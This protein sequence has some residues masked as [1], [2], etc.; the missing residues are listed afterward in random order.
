MNAM[1]SFRDSGRIERSA[2][3]ESA[4]LFHRCPV[5]GAEHEVSMARARF[6]YGRQLTCGPDCEAEC[7]RRLLAAYRA[8]PAQSP[9]GTSPA[10]RRPEPADPAGERDRRNQ[11]ALRL[12]NG[13]EPKVVLSVTV[14][15]IDMLRVRRAAFQSIGG[16]VGVMKAAPVPHSSKV[17]LFVS[18]KADA[19]DAI[20]DSIMRAVPAGEFGHAHCAA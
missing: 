18:A 13:N 3:Y 11:G 5:C 15:S 12:V 20:R 19:L 4:A 14:E 16:S 7:R 1:Q 6:A 9:N 10:I 17:R 2:A 8:A